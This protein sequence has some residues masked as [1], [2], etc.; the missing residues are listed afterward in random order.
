MGIAQQVDIK[1]VKIAI[2]ASNG[3]DLDAIL[4]VRSALRDSGISSLIVG[5]HPGAIKSAQG[6]NIEVDSILSDEDCARYDGVFIPGGS[7]I[8]R[9]CDDENTISFVRNA[10]KNGKLVASS[11]GGEKLVIKAAQS[12]KMPNGAFVGEG[13]ISQSDNDSNFLKR[14][15]AAITHTQSFNRP[16][17]DFITN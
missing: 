6:V 9:L 11:E 8:D 17:I 16:D 13:V 5:C 7:G 12:A 15:L 10:Y 1:T 3:V 14:F 4:A 2:L